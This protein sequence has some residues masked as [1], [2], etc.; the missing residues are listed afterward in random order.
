MELAPQP[1]LTTAYPTTATSTAA[2]GVL[3]KRWQ[4]TGDQLSIASRNTTSPLQA[5]LL[6]LTIQLPRRR[7]DGQSSS[8]WYV[9]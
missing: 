7:K 8:N 6:H 5:T 3:T 1:P 9:D 2:A 4:A